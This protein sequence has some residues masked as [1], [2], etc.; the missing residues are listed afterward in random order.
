MEE[1]TIKEW[2]YEDNGQRKGPVSEAE[3]KQFIDDGKLSYGS[4]IWQKGM[5][6]WIKIEDSDLKTY[7]N[8]TAPPPLHGELVS[9]KVVW[10]LAFA[11]IIGLMLEYFIAGAV[12]SNNEHAATA[13]A[14]NADF[15]YVTLMLNIGLAYLDEKRLRK[16]GHNT[17]K[18]KGMTWLVPVYLYQRAKNLKQ[19]LAYFIVWIV[20]FVLML[21]S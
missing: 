8:D 3:M 15:W 7:L 21:F 19:N 4:A 14:E 20:C 17:D 12:H 9:N 5:A 1:K 6:E 11:P 13:A 10:I 18:F 2:H 16:A